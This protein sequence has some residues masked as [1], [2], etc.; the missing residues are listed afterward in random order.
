MGG[1]LDETEG[2]SVLQVYYQSGSRNSQHQDP[3]LLEISFNE[4]QCSPIWWHLQLH[5]VHI[6]C[7]EREGDFSSLLP[8]EMSLLPLLS[9]T[10][11]LLL[12]TKEGRKPQVQRKAC[13]TRG[14]HLLKATSWF[15]VTLLYFI[16]LTFSRGVGLQSKKV[17]WLVWEDR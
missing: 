8:W 11:D 5:P 12:W 16:L 2:E 9:F 6:T 10:S 4:F 1:S 17:C 13:G 3:T 15:L 14:C 7:L